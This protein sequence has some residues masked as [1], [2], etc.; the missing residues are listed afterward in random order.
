MRED[1]KEKLEDFKKFFN[2]NGM[3]YSYIKLM[4]LAVKDDIFLQL[5]ETK[6]Y[7][8]KLHLEINELRIDLSNHESNRKVYSGEPAS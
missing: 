6:E 2:A 5:E 3:D 4:D 1:L 8:E 7:V